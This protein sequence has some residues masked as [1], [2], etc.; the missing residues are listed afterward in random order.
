LSK[1]ENEERQR[2]SDSGTEREA[3]V[4]SDERV[5]VVAGNLAAVTP[6]EGSN[7]SRAVSRG[8]V[9]LVLAQG[10]VASPADIADVAP[11][12]ERRLHVSECGKIGSGN[13]VNNAGGSEGGHDTRELSAVVEVVVEASI[14]VDASNAHVAA[15]VWVDIGI[16]SITKIT[17]DSVTVTVDGAT[18]SLGKCETILSNATRDLS[19]QGRAAGSEGLEVAGVPIVEGITVL[20]VLALI[21]VAFANINKV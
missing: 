10:E 6:R 12:F 11:H 4:D 20:R 8:G 13:G 18:A 2:V 3:G 19:E 21:G 17:V 7:T 5:A 14:R 9:V 1:R 16:A 15:M